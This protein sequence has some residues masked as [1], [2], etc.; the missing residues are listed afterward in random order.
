MEAFS[1]KNK[2]PFWETKSLAEMTPNEWERL[3]DGCG[4]CCLTKLQDEETDEI[5]YTRVVCRYSDLST[6]ACS[7]YEN[8]SVNVPS[9]VALTLER[10]AEFDWLP[11]TCAYRVLY[12]GDPLPEWHPLISGQST[13]V[14]AANIGLLAIPVVLDQDG[15]DYEDYVIDSL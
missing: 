3:C 2:R 14:Q 15:L 7:D 11:E 10:V 6:A 13:S 12:R 4:L 5:V 1:N 8:R 9:C